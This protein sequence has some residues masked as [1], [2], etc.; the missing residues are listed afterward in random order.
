MQAAAQL[1]EVTKDLKELAAM[2]QHATSI[3]KAQKDIARLKQ[4]IAGLE[5]DLL[6]SG[7]AKTADEVQE[8][9]DKVSTDLYVVLIICTVFYMLIAITGERTSARSRTSSL[10]ATGRTPRCG[11]S[12]RTYTGWS[13]RRASAETSCAT[14]TSWSAGS[15]R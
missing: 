6:A 8:E 9:L 14:R 10:T 7:T 15:R 12:R 13:S 1:S 11:P 3:T 2:Q 5:T 4:E